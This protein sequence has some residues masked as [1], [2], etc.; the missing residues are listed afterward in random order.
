V[1]GRRLLAL[2]AASV[3]AC[4]LVAALFGTSDPARRAAI[5]GVG[6]VAAM[7]GISVACS[8]PHEG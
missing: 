5:E 4:A 7:V 1:P 6:I 8:R 3:W 2:S